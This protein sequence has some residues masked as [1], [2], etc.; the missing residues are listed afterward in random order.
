MKYDLLNDRMK[1]IT[2]DDKYYLVDRFNNKYR[3]LK[4]EGLTKI[5]DYKN[6]DYIDKI[7]DLKELGITNYKVDL[8]EESK[9]EIIN[10]VERINAFIK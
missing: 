4:E 3:I 7:S 9:E 6:V 8:L 10:I 1:E 5:I 2:N